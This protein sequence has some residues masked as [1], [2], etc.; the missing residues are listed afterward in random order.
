MA[1]K[2]HFLSV[3][4]SLLLLT[5]ASVY[6]GNLT[7]NVAGY[8]RDNLSRTL[9]SVASI[10][11]MQSSMR[12]VAPTATRST[13]LSPPESL[14]SGRRESMDEHRKSLEALFSRF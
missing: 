4:L 14:P 2:S 3:I 5:G 13:T 7:L 6:S 12:M 11:L 9:H 1:A 10:P 8:G